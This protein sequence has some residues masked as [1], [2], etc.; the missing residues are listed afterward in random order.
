MRKKMEQ[1]EQNT[2]D[3]EDEIG[4]KSNVTDNN[5]AGAPSP[6]ASPLPSDATTL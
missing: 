6:P 1:E 2:D 5:D 3:T 4:E